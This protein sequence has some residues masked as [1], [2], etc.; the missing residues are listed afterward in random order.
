MVKSLI[1][2]YN[3]KIRATELVHIRSFVAS[4]GLKQ[5]NVIL[6]QSKKKGLRGLDHKNKMGAI[7]PILMHKIP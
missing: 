7:I 6:L 3:R 4:V 2:T 5:R 1:Q